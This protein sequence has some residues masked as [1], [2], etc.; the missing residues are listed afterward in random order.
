MQKFWSHMI[1]VDHGEA[2]LFSDHESGGPMWAGDGARR[3]ETEIAFAESFRSV[4]AVTVHLAMWDVASG[5]NSRGDLRAEH[6]TERGFVLVFRTW[7]DSR[8]A[9]VR[10]TWQALG[11]VAHG[12]DW[13]L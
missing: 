8:V 13:E 10:A 11:E 4:P 9:R 5:S 2:I 6:V 3:A 12:D 1:G 7:G